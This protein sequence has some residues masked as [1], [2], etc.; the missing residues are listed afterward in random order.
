[1][2]R[3]G[4]PFLLLHLAP[5]MHLCACFVIALAAPVRGW[6]FLVPVDFPASIPLI[7]LLYNHDLP[8]PVFGTVGTAWWYFLGYVARK[9][10][11]EHYSLGKGGG[12]RPGG[13]AQRAGDGSVSGQPW[14]I[15]RSENH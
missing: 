2:R 15:P 12:A 8:L 14:R 6:Q 1:M 11:V 5:L 4:A 7:A 10:W 13:Q 3:P 9:R